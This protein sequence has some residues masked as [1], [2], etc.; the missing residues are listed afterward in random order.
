ME[1][2]VDLGI[3]DK[4]GWPRTPSGAK[5]KDNLLSSRQTHRV[6]TYAKY[7]FILAHKKRAPMGCCMP[8]DAE[9]MKHNLAYFIDMYR[10]KS[11][12]EFKKA[13]KAVLE[14]YFNN[15][16]FC[17]GVVPCKQVEGG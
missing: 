15:H 6:C 3:L 7:F 4:L 17:G 12:K 10:H 8:K 2:M 14:H 16:A 1:T 5:K 13:A 9:H 11:F